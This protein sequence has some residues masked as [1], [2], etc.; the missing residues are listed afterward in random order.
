M[1]II[2]LN[3][4]SIQRRHVAGIGKQN[5]FGITLRENMLGQTAIKAGKIINYE[6][7]GTI[8]FIVDKDVEFLLY[9]QPNREFKLNMVLEKVTYSYL[10]GGN[11]LKK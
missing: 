7:T 10:Q 2:N 5:I 9:G 6:K 4:C 8:E 3:D 11:K 1:L